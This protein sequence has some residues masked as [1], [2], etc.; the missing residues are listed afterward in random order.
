MTLK[1]FCKDLRYDVG[2]IPAPQRARLCHQNGAPLAG[3]ET[4]FQSITVSHL[5][6]GGG[7]LSILS[8]SRCRLAVHEVA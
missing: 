1:A 7:P 6:G 5:P 8:Q 4:P 3:G 2:T